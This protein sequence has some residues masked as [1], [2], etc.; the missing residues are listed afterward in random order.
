MPRRFHKKSRNGCNQCKER[1]VKVGRYLSD[2]SHLGRLDADNTSVTRHGPYAVHVPL[3]NYPASIAYLVLED[4]L[5]LRPLRN[6]I[7]NH[8]PSQS[9][10]HQNMMPDICC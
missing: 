5:Q 10:H 3:G 8:G 6:Q 9:L 4:N 7:P 1:R 2:V